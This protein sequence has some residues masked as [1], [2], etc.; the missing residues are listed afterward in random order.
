MIFGGLNSVSNG[1][2]DT[3]PIIRS[4]SNTNPNEADF[5]SARLSSARL[6]YI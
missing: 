5:P 6:T 1:S 2:E 4:E 3:V